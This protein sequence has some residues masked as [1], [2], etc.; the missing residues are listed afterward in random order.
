[1]HWR[2]TDMQNMQDLKSEICSIVEEIN[3]EKVLIKLRIILL[4]IITQLEE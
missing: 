1:V 2:G 4:D 3:D